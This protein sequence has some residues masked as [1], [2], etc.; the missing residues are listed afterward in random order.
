MLYSQAEI[1]EAAIRAY[2]ASAC[3]DP[4]YHATKAE[5]FVSRCVGSHNM[6][7]DDDVECCIEDTEQVIDEKIIEDI[8]FATLD[9]TCTKELWLALSEI[10]IR[11]IPRELLCVSD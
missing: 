8:A 11:P 9:D 6:E 5:A 10:E 7:N 1:H 4:T 2:Q 3:S